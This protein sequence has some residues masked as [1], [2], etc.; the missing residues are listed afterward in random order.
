MDRRH[1]RVRRPVALGRRPVPAQRARLRRRGAIAAAILMRAVPHA[2]HAQGWRDRSRDLVEVIEHET[3][4]DLARGDVRP[5][6]R[7][8]RRAVRLGR[9]MAVSRRLVRLAR[10]KQW[11]KNVL[12]IAA[13]G[14]AGV[15]GEATA[16]VPHR[17]RVR[18]LLPRRERHL[19]HQRRARR[20]SRPPPPD[21]ALPAD[22]VGRVPVRAAI[23]GG[24]VLDRRGDRLV[25]RR[26]AGSSRSSS[27]VT[28]C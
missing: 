21:E 1:R 23:V 15:L 18:V 13:P 28:S 7:F 22:R 19:L 10:P 12:V 6:N 3:A 26:P 14:A 20:R 16:L 17:D 5:P 9:C 25:V 2:A 11:V 4:R 27:A 24:V 8:P